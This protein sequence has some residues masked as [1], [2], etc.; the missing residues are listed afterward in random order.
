MP[1][2]GSSAGSG[3]RRVRSPEAGSGNRV[4]TRRFISSPAPLADTDV[5]SNTKREEWTTSKKVVNHKTRQ[6]ETRVQRQLVLEDGKVIADTGP[7]ITTRTTEDNKVEESED[8][9]HK[10]TGDEDVPDGY[11]PVPGSE[12]VVCE[13]TESHQVTKETKEENMKMHDENF[14][15]LRGPEEIHRLAVMVPDESPLV[16]IRPDRFPGKL[17]H[18]SSRSRKVTDKDE[19]KEISEERNGEVTKQTTRTHHHE[20]KDDDEVPDDEAEGKDLP[21]VERETKRNFEYLHDGADIKVPDR[22][23]KQKDLLYLQ[24]TSPE[25]HD[26]V[27]RRALSLEEEEEIRNS[28]TNRWLDNHFGSE[29][30]DD[31]VVKSKHGGNVI[32][33]KMTDT[34]R[35]PTPPAKPP[36]ESPNLIY[37]TPYFKSPTP[38]PT[39]LDSTLRSTKSQQKTASYRREEKVDDSR[40]TPYFKSPTP[41]PTPLDSTLRSTK[42]Q[43]K[44][45]S[46]RREEKVDDSRQSRAS[47]RS[48]WKSSPSIYHDVTRHLDESPTRYTKVD[49]SYRDLESSYRP[50]EKSAIVGNSVFTK[51]DRR[52]NE[53]RRVTSEYDREVKKQPPPERATSPESRPIQRSQSTRTPEKPVAQPPTYTYSLPR[54][55]SSRRATRVDQ[56]SKTSRGVQADLDDE[57][58]TPPSSRYIVHSVRETQSLPRHHHHHHRHHHHHSSSSHHR[59]RSEETEHHRRSGDRN[60]SPESNISTASRPSKTFYFG[61]KTDTSYHNSRHKDG[62]FTIEK[63]RYVQPPRRFRSDPRERYYSVEDLTTTT[64]SYAT[65]PTPSA[66]KPSFIDRQRYYPATPPASPP[67]RL[68]KIT[69]GRSTSPSPPESP[70]PTST[71]HLLPPPSPYASLNRR[72]RSPS[73]VVNPPSFTPLQSPVE[74][75]RQ[76]STS[77]YSRSYHHRSATADSSGAKPGPSVIEVRNWDS[78]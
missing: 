55:Q 32:N 40:S 34:K 58:Y 14:K 61:D 76:Q 53:S 15:E 35:T 50:V 60:R 42:S 27:T 10:K 25:R 29:T 74:V 78:R 16:G 72:Y 45:T 17:T 62:Y 39:P 49:R 26:P 75:K 1:S 7:Q 31:D 30:S 56:A 2:D 4:V 9:Q 65:A 24:A 11:V 18:Y 71:S 6:T 19:V 33:V 51:E 46:Y 52:L 28:E 69:N 43:Q 67:P 20:E 13:K 8:T 64:R 38:S 37:T 77:S 5:I 3:V 44:T 48:N 63:D 54:G 70:R 47:P 66:K 73:P 23:R 36:R 59:H 68:I 21:A 41:S 12:R 57:P 22:M